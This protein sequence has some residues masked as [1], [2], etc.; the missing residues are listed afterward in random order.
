MLYRKGRRLLLFSRWDDYHN[1][2]SFRISYRVAKHIKE[3]RLSE[4][5][6]VGYLRLVAVNHC[7]Y[8]FEGAN[9]IVP[10]NGDIGRCFYYDG[11]IEAYQR[12][13]VSRSTSW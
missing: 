1:L 8:S 7:T 5:I 6:K 9:L 10:G 2:P 3:D 13:Y 11:K 12:T 4:G